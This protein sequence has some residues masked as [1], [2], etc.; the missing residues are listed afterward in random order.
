VE[1]LIANAAECE[2][3]LKK[4]QKILEY[5]PEKVFDGLEL[6][7]RAAGAQKGVLGIKKKHERII[8]RLKE[9]AK[10]R[11]NISVLEMGDYYPAGDEQSAR[12]GKGPFG[13]HQ[14]D[15]RDA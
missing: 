1:V 13:E 9:I 14:R 10:A 3:L 7:M 5:F 4:D 8:P 12:Q 2:P 15:Q 6:L 11:R